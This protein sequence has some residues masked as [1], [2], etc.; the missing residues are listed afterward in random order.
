MHRLSIICQTI[1]CR[2]GGRGGLLLAGAAALLLAGAG[3]EVDSAD[4]SISINPSAAHVNQVGQ[5]VTL[6]A[7]GGYRY[8]W[9][10]SNNQIGRL[11]TYA[12]SQVHYTSLA[13]PSATPEVQVVTVASHF[14]D[15]ASEN[16]GGTT[17]NGTT[18]A[19]VHTAEA[20]ITHIPLQ[21]AS[22][23]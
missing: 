19:V 2:A 6:N 23:N 8:Q 21:P 3:C 7:S 18:T 11:D 17:T 13:Q 10:L 22:T 4:S 12:G 5:T 16:S 15:N 14:S 9:S 1:V 20:Y